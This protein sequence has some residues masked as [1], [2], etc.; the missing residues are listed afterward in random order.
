V[1]TDRSLGREHLKG[2]WGVGM[3]FDLELSGVA[4]S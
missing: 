1:L 2:S 3:T 4:G